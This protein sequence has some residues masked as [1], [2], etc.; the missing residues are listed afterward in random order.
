[1]PSVGMRLALAAFAV[2]L[3]ALTG[4]RVYLGVTGKV[5]FTGNGVSRI[6]KP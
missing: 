5:G 3:I 1:M 6:A 4:Y 2:F